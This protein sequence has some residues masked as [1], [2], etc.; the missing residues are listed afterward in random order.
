MMVALPPWASMWAFP[1]PWQLSQPSFSG[2]LALL[3]SALEVW[4]AEKLVDNQGVTGLAGVA[5]NIIG[6]LRKS[7][8]EE[9]GLNHPKKL[10]YLI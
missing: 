7:G 3:A 10:H 9:G 5:A 6:G 4:I 8:Q 1:G 2:A